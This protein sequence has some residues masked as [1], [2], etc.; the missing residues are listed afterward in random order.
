MLIWCYTINFFE[1]IDQLNN[2][3]SCV[4]HHIGENLQHWTQNMYLNL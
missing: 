4:T 2:R 1:Y 3:Y